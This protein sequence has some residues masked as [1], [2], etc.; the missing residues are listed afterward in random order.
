MRRPPED[1]FYTVGTQVGTSR[2]HNIPVGPK[3]ELSFRS[4]IYK[5]S[6]YEMCQSTVERN[7]PN[8]HIFHRLILAETKF[9]KG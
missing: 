2:T 1:I 9:E 8:L 3:F 4:L 7:N 5:N 6:L